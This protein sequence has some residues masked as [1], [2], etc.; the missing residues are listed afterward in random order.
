VPEQYLVTLNVYGMLQ[1]VT[2]FILML[3]LFHK[4]IVLLF[5]A[6]TIEDDHLPLLY[7]DDAKF[8]SQ[9]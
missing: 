3:I 7:G 8:K 2:V 6:L 5:L 9:I 1:C 4:L